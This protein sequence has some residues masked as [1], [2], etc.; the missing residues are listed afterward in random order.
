M[1]LVEWEIKNNFLTFINFIFLKDSTLNPILRNKKAIT[2]FDI[3]SPIIFI[4]KGRYSW[5]FFI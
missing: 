3:Y 4:F 1:N 2:K 5:K